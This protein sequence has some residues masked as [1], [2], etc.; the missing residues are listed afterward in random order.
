MNPKD[1]IGY[2]ILTTTSN[3]SQF[4][5]SAYVI[6][7]KGGTLVKWI[8]PF[9]TISQLQKVP[10]FKLRFFNQKHI[11][12]EFKS[13]KKPIRKNPAEKLFRSAKLNFS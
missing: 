4:S 1:K 8:C 6:K 9:L 7:T 10:F 5:F 13:I 3:R 12:P 11:H 2:Q